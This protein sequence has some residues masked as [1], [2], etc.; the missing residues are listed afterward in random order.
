MP[1]PSSGLLFLVPVVRQGFVLD[2]DV[3]LAVGSVMATRSVAV[4]IPPIRLQFWTE[5]DFCS[6]F[7]DSGQVLELLRSRLGSEVSELPPALDSAQRL[8]LTDKKLVPT[9]ATRQAVSCILSSGDF[10]APEDADGSKYDPSFDIGIRSFAWPVLVQA[11]GLA[12]K[13]GDALTLTAAGKKALIAPPPDVVRKLWAAWLKTRA[14]DEFAWVDA[15]KGKCLRAGG[16]FVVVREA[17]LDIVR[18]TVRKLGSVAWC[19]RGEAVR[20]AGIA[21]GCLG[22]QPTTTKPFPARTTRGSGKS[23][24]PPSPTTDIASSPSRSPDAGP[25]ANTDTRVPGSTPSR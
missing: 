1:V 17:D 23:T 10:Y 20:C 3:V 12:E 22:S 21:P 19:S 11:G 13:N 24:Q 8:G 16:R 25:R 2:I 4:T 15:I 9:E 7:G 5:R 18:K 14:F 6:P